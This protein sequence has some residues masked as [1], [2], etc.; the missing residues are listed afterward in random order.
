MLHKDLRGQSIYLGEQGDHAALKMLGRQPL[1]SSA[2]IL[3]DEL[4]PIER[5]L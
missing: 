2:I 3:A 1:T 4:G 5:K